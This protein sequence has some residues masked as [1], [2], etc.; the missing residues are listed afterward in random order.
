MSSSMVVKS[1]SPREVKCIPVS[2]QRAKNFG[3]RCMAKS[4]GLGSRKDCRVLVPEL[5]IWAKALGVTWDVVRVGDIILSI[6][7]PGEELTTLVL[8]LFTSGELDSNEFDIVTAFGT[9]SKFVAKL[10][11]CGLHEV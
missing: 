11:S 5:G 3:R 10:V 8:E 9:V 6:R 7:M 2:I 1:T 4:G